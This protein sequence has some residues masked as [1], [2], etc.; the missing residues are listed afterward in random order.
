VWR[1]KGTALKLLWTQETTQF[2]GE[3]VK[4]T[5]S[6]SFPKPIQKP[7]PPVLLGAAYHPEEGK[8]VAALCDGWILVWGWGP[9]LREGSNAVRRDFESAGRDPASLSLSLISPE[10]G[11]GGKRSW[12]KWKE[13]LPDQR[14][15][16]DYIGIGIS[17]LILGL[18][19]HDRDLM[20]RCLDHL[21][22]VTL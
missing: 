12:E 2:D 1:E 17:R 7:H 8:D 19:L 3:V 9:E 20:Y 14:T 18:P 6:W 15:L 22:T 11:M 5:E 21:A 16:D 13:A 10:G 4:F